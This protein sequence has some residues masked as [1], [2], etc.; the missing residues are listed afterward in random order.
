MNGISILITKLLNNL[1]D[2]IKIF[3]RSKFSDDAFKTGIPVSSSR[4]NLGILILMPTRERQP[5]A[6]RRVCHSR[7]AGRSDPCCPISGSGF[8]AHIII[9]FAGPAADGNL[10][11]C[12]RFHVGAS[13]LGARES[14]NGGRGARGT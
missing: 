10:A 2:P 7:R 11:S 14:R 12:E 1:L 8:Q 3:G 5:S 6:C 13:A 9:Q 4:A